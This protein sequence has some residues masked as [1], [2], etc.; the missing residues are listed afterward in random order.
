MV[1]HK[2]G[3]L[4][5]TT[6]AET[7]ATPAMTYLSISRVI[8]T[9]K[10]IFDTDS[11]RAIAE[12]NLISES[13]NSLMI[14]YG[15]RIMSI[16]VYTQF[17]PDSRSGDQSE[18]IIDSTVTESEPQPQ[19]WPHQQSPSVVVTILDDN[20]CWPDDNDCWPENS[21]GPCKIDDVVA[22]SCS[23]VVSS[24]VGKD[25][26]TEPDEPTSLGAS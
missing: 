24:V 20:D 6:L 12:F 25:K 21:H 7:V 5:D 17:F 1:D 22:E 9:F 16:I 3:L 13:K 18:S 2:N 23:I 10:A 14:R 26:E 8:A 11:F 4:I 15:D 19:S